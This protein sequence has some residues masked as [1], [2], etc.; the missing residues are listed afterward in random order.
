MAAALAPLL[1]PLL[2]SAGTTL[3]PAIIDLIGE[4]AYDVLSPHA[5]KALDQLLNSGFIEKNIKKIGN[6][7]YNK[8]KTARKIMNKGKKLASFIFGDKGK[9]AVSEGLKLG[10]ALGAISPELSN[11]VGSGYTKALGFHDMLSEINKPAIGI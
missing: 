3:A 10:E 2:K 11:K 7:L 9:K 5:M 8:N 6:K 1:G 4:N